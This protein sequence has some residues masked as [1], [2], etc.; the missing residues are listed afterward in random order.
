MSA[1]PLHPCSVP[2]CGQLLEPHVLMC[3]AH[4]KRVP[5]RLRA[6]VWAAWERWR[7]GAIDLDALREV[8]ARATEAVCPRKGGVA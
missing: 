4:W 6:D 8:Q 5:Y 2:G 7:C 3:R 1:K